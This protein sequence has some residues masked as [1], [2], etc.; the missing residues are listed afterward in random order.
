[1][2][3]SRKIVALAGMMM[4]PL[5]GRAATP[6]PD[7][8]TA[9][10]AAIAASD[11]TNGLPA[12]LLTAI[13]TVE[14]GRLDRRTGLIRPWPWVIDIGGH[15]QMFD[16]ATDAITAVQAA[17][18]QG[19]QSID[20]GCM[21]V[22]LAF[23][24]HAFATLQ[25]AFDPAANVRY[26][27]GFLGRLHAQSGDWGAAIAAYHSANPAFGPAYA[28]TVAAVWRLAPSYG[29]V[30]AH[31]R[32][33]NGQSLEDEVDPGR[34]LTPE[35][36]SQMVAALAFQREHFGQLAPQSISA[37]TARGTATGALPAPRHGKPTQA[38]L[39]AEVD[40][41]HT[42]TPAFR[43][44]MMEAVAFQHRVDAAFGTVTLA[45]QK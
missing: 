45:R 33:G 16:T 18:A 14:S 25:E 2:I 26:A 36:R 20:V 34:V 44:Q 21:Q 11:R 32:S 17:Q 23:H 4:L 10:S 30:G 28:E 37:V 38:S 6:P 1:M 35:F 41:G 5:S 3:L 12:Q 7:D 13:G 29:L 40:P 19:I 27:A 42:L 22:N 24:P 39:A 31:Q 8:T 43:Q 15:G 9:C